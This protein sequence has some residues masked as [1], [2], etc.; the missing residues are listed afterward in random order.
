[1]AACLL[2]PGFF[3]FLVQVHGHKGVQF[4]NWAKTYGCCPE[5]YYQPTS[6]EEVREVGVHLHI[7]PR[8]PVLVTTA[9]TPSRGWRW[10]FLGLDPRTAGPAQAP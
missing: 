1:M 4:Q 2:K 10:N 5:M 7:T 8:C 9:L 3:F 6:V